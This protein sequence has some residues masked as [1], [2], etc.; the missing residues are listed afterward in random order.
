MAKDWRAK[1]ALRW[2]NKGI[3]LAFP[4]ANRLLPGGFTDI[5]GAGKYLL[6]Q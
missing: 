5:S 2:D 6:D 1:I 3:L 4:G